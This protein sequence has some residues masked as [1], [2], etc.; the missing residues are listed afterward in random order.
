MPKLSQ[1]FFSIFSWSRISFSGDLSKLAFP[2]ASSSYELSSQPWTEPSNIQYTTPWVFNFKIPILQVLNRNTLVNQT[3]QCKIPPFTK[4]LPLKENSNLYILWGFPGLPC[5]I[6][7]SPEPCA[8]PKRCQRTRM[9]KSLLREK[10]SCPT[11]NFTP[12]LA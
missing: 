12:P 4:G 5:L 11:P 8:L 6:P 2:G 10:A 9:T 3:W 7:A 1:I